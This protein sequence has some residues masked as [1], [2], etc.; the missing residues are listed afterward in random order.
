MM[1]F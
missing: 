1:V